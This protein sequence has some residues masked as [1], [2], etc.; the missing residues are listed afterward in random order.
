MEEDDKG[1]WS[2][3]NMGRQEHHENQCAW[4]VCTGRMVPVKMDDLAAS[5][6]TSSIPEKLWKGEHGNARAVHIF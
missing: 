4:I 5:P 2:S 3:S 6:S 1:C